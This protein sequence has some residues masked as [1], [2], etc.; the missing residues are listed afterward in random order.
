ML[1][2]SGQVSVKSVLFSPAG[3]ICSLQICTAC[4]C[5]SSHGRC[6]RCSSLQRWVC[7]GEVSM[8]ARLLC[9]GIQGA[10]IHHRTSASFPH[11]FVLPALACARMHAPPDTEDLNARFVSSP[12]Q[13][14]PRYMWAG[15]NPGLFPILVILCTKQAAWLQPQSQRAGFGQVT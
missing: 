11:F 5:N 3:W 15:T 7:K 12:G 13:Y 9:S 6:S 4:Y 2:M 14:C 10:L 8:G 1:C